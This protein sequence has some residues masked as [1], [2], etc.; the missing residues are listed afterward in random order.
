MN[1]VDTLVIVFLLAFDAGILLCWL[2]SGVADFIASLFRRRDPPSV[3]CGC[4]ATGLGI[5]A[6][7]L[8]EIQRCNHD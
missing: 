8:K 5:C 2:A 6:T 3:P 7:A 1:R 4:A